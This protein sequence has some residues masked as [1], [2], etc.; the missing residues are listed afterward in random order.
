MKGN[1]Q[2]HCSQTNDD[3][4]A[5]L[6]LS[7]WLWITQLYLLFHAKEM[8]KSPTNGYEYE[9]VP[10]FLSASCSFA[11]S[12]TEKKDVKNYFNSRRKFHFLGSLT[13]AK[14]KEISICW[15]VTNQ[16]HTHIAHR[17][18]SFIFTPT[19]WRRKSS[20]WK[21]LSLWCKLTQ[22]ELFRFLT[23]LRHANRLSQ[24]RRRR[25][26]MCQLAK[27]ASIKDGLR[28]Q[29]FLRQYC[30]PWRQLTMSLQLEMKC[31]H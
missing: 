16:A 20:G 21:F 24:R 26:L 29:F 17:L 6:H 2:F 12:E 1:V 18:H 23:W 7:I 13:R 22:L 3:E 8:Q 15:H 30:I 25:N 19:E 31:S 5:R 27:S 11:L 28:L 14:G 4:I 9:V 10:S